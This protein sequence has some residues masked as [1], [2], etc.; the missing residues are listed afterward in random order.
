MELKVARS[1][2]IFR[3]AIVVMIGAHIIKNL[4]Q[5]WKKYRKLKSE[6]QF[7]QGDINPIPND[8]AEERGAFCVICISSP[9]NIIVIPCMHLGLCVACFLALRK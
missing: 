9:S 4:Y 5:R 3:I 1:Y 7:F 6:E 2:T 8:L